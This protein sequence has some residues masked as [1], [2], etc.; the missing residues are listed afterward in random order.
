MDD[1]ADDR[2]G[3]DS[4]RDGP[5]AGGRVAE[6]PPEVARHRAGPAELLAAAADPDVEA[7]D[8]HEIREPEREAE[9]EHGDAGDDRLLEAVAGGDEDVRAPDRR[10]A[11][12]RTGA[13]RPSAAPSRPRAPSASRPP[14][15]SAWSRA[16]EH[17]S[18]QKR[19]TLYIRP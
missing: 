15:S 1:D 18:E 12:P 5:P 13:S 2:S 9:D 7:L 6:R 16:S 14:R 3:E 4:E 10:A 17:A 11:A 19:K 8:E